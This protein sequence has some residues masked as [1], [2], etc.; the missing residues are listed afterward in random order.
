MAQAARA[1][2]ISAWIACAAARGSRA[3]G[4][5][6]ADHQHV[7]AGRHGSGGP[8]RAL[9][10]AGDA[11]GG[12]DARDDQREVGRETAAQ[13]GDLVRRADDA[14][15]TA[16]PGQAGE[17]SHVRRHLLGDPERG[18]IGV[19]EAGQHGHADQSRARL[20]G[21]G[22]FDRGAQHRRAAR[23]VQGQ[24]GD[25]ERAR[26]LDRACHGVGDVVELEIEEHRQP[27]CHDPAHAVRP[28]RRDEL[29][30]DLEAVD[31]AVERPGKGE[32]AVEVRPVERAVDGGGLGHP[33][34]LGRPA[35][36]RAPARC[37]PGTLRRGARLRAARRCCSRRQREHGE[38]R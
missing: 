13:Q 33:V 25:A 15:Q 31:H 23:D 28:V 18:Q 7:R 27:E 38:P 32:R 16:V 30:A 29:E 20:P 34:L 17:A 19:I 6:P 4:D 14:V 35:Y 22:R 37:E 36:S 26:R 12:S 24:H 2:A 3:C 11:A 9:L 8:L 10:V 1:A 21:A 5:R